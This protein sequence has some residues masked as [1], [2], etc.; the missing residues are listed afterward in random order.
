MSS[1]KQIPN[2]YFDPCSYI[3]RNIYLSTALKSQ[4]AAAPGSRDGFLVP[5]SPARLEERVLVLVLPVVVTV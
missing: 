5:V 4:T 1:L 2:V 3:C